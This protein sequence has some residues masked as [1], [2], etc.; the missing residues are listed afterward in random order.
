[1]Y[2]SHAPKL[3]Q[4]IYNH[5]DVLRLFSPLPPPRLRAFQKATYSF[6]SSIDA[7]PTKLTINAILYKN[8]SV[9]I[10]RGIKVSGDSFLSLE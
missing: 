9:L 3:W 6:I 5:F 2:I 7:T 10:V 8:M 1:M 4:F